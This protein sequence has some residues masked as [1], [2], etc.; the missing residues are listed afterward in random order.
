MGLNACD[1]RGC[2][3]KWPSFHLTFYVQLFLSGASFLSYNPVGVINN[4][5]R[6][7]TTITIMGNS[8]AEIEWKL[9]N[10]LKTDADWFSYNKLSLNIE[11]THFM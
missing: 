4:N 3:I 10:T 11:K 1:K 9:N 2:F 6:F 7:D 8:S 5:G